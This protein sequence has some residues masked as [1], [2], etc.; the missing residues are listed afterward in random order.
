[1]RS[2]MSQFDRALFFV[3]CVGV[4]AIEHNSSFAICPD[5]EPR[6]KTLFTRCDVAFIGTVISERGIEYG[7]ENDEDYHTGLFYKMKVKQVFRG[8]KEKVIEVYEDNDSGRMGLIKGHAYL[9]F[10]HRQKDGKLQGWCNDA[11]DS[12]DKSFK[13]KILELKEVQK[14]IKAGVNGDIRGFV[15]DGEGEGYKGV[16]GIH[17]SIKGEGKVY[18]AVSDKNVW[19]YVSVP[20]GHY[21][22]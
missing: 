19:F 18:S 7:K 22:V 17:F 11:L 1:M 13:S 4:F 3:L 8:L 2:P 14:N 10:V 16:E 20:A 9:V 5:P 12:N 15:E 21:K 6:I